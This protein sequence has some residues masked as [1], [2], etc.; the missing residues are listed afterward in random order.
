MIPLWGSIRLDCPLAKLN[1][2]MI[3]MFFTMGSK[4]LSASDWPK[5]SLLNTLSACIVQF[6]MLM[7][8]IGE[9]INTLC[10]V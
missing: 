1:L 5:W 3:S 9:I 4:I 8:K 10:R 7:G 2:H 6:F